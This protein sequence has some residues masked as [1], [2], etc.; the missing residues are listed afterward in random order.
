MKLGTDD[1]SFAMSGTCR[2]AASESFTDEEH[3]EPAAEVM[4]L[5]D[6]MAGGSKSWKKKNKGKRSRRTSQQDLHWFEQQEES[7]TDTAPSGQTEDRHSD[8][9]QAVANEPARAVHEVEE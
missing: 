2:F 3:A 5:D 4:T 7:Q 8:E 9:W 1:N 6:S